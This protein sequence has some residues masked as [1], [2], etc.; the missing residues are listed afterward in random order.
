MRPSVYQYLVV[1]SPP[2]EIKQKV[3]GLRNGLKTRVYL[4]THN[5]KSI[6]YITVGTFSVEKPLD[7]TIGDRFQNLFG[8]E[9]QFL[10][11]LK[12]V[13]YFD[14]GRQSKTIYMGVEDGN[15]IEGFY[16]KLSFILKETPK[17]FTP[18]L[19]I[20]ST[21]PPAVFDT[22]F[23]FLKS[24][25]FEESFTCNNLLILERSFYNG[26]VSNYSVFKEIKLL[27]A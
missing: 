26:I 23:P 25:A 5:L 24:N 16:K 21:I 22:A 15:V 27:A 20:A 19:S 8:D 7:K 10:I 18:H 12:P 1:I 6:P 14:H 3:E 2:Q 17:T 4:G 13:N 9:R 11:T